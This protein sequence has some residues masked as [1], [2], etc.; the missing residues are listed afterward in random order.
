MFIINIIK[1][2]YL[3]VLLMKSFNLFCHLENH[4]RGKYNSKS[5]K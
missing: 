2:L 3:N 4:I 5:T 1:P